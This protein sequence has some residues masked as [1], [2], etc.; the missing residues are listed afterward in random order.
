MIGTILGIF[1]IVITLIFGGYS[2]W[3][4]KKSKKKVSL[5]FRNKEC[6][7]LF[8]EDVNRLNIE[9]IYNK[10]TLNNTLVLLK[11]KL[12]N[13]GHI[14]I[15]KNRIY[16]PLKIKSSETYN[17]LEATVTSSPKG[18]KTNIE[19]LNGQEVQLNWDLLKQNEYIE[20][21]AL[22]EITGKLEKEEE[23][24]NDFYNNLS[25]D[26]RITDLNSI[27]KEKQISNSTRFRSI[28]HKVTK[29]MGIITILIG[30]LFLT[31]EIVPELN[32]MDKQVVNYA[33]K[34]DSSELVSIIASKHSD[35]ITLSI[36]GENEKRK[37]SVEEF[38][39]SYKI[40]GIKKTSLDP[41]SSLFNRVIGIV[42][43]IMGILLL[44]LKR[45]KKK[46]ANTVYN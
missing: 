46:A 9:L 26:Y 33:I 42:Y 25:F 6:Y 41:K 34:K 19:L 45:K 35:E 8:R 13:N 39:N 5:E 2:I 23:K 38:N 40:E 4:Y 7:S 16:T 43:I 30:I 3:V 15:D 14:D 22:V 12:I 31:F 24:G 37:I 32:F 1:G 36:E 29:V 20:I 44:Y 18:A 21:E 17:W 11:A 27:Q 28:Y 10:T